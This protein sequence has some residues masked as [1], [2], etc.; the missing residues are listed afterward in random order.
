MESPRKCRY[1]RMPWSAVQPQSRN[2]PLARGCR[3][4]TVLKSGGRV[5]SARNG[6][7]VFQN[8]PDGALEF[9][10][11]DGFVKI[12]RHTEGKRICFCLGVTEGRHQDDRDLRG[13]LAK[14]GHI[15]YSTRR[16]AKIG[17][18]EGWAVIHDVV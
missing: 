10:D 6:F 17:H 7:P 3:R 16:H 1:W 4:V 14:T 2:V 15:A 9:G 11:P 18:D 12:G 13:K 8:I 5:R